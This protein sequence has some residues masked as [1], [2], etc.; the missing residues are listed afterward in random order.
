MCHLL[1]QIAHFPLADDIEFYRKERESFVEMKTANFIYSKQPT[2]A[3]A[4]K[5]D[6]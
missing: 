4:F 2:P 6:V 1:I 3:F 5:N